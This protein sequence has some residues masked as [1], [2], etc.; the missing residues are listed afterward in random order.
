LEGFV[1]IVSLVPSLTE[2]LFALGLTCDEVV[3]RTAWCIHPKNIVDDVM[4]IGGTKTPNLGKIRKL[5][6][7]LIVM[8]KEENPFSVYQ[9]LTDEGYTIFVSEVTS[10]NDVPRMLQEL[11]KVCN[12][13]SVGEEL[14]SKCKDSLESLSQNKPSVKTVP[15]IWHK[16]LMAVSPSKY[17]GAILTSVGFNVV[18]TKPQGNGYPEISIEDFIEHEIELI[19]LTSEPHNFSTE[20]GVSIVEKIVSAGGVSP[21]VA[22]IDGED[23]TWFGSRTSSAL[24][25]LVN[26]RVQVLEK[27]DD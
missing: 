14:A 21:K 20:E 24:T 27:M 13:E 23:L 11:G 19:L 25:R 9:T 4:V 22:H 12:K 26:F 10:P 18:N 7:D 17:P 6:P 15:L 5:N 16:P 1:R 3:G 8:D 2:T